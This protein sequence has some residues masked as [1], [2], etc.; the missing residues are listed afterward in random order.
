MMMQRIASTVTAIA[1]G[2]GLSAAARAAYPE[3]PIKLVV[4]YTPAGSGDQLARALAQNVGQLLQQPVVVE[5]KPGAST[6]IGATQV[7]R[8]PADGYTLFLASNASMVLNPLLY[9]SFPYDPERDFR[10]VAIVADLPLVVITNDKSG[11]DSMQKFVDYA[12]QNPGKLNYASVG[13]GNPL[14]LATELLLGKY[15]IKATHVPYNGSAPALTSLMANDTQLMIDVISTSLPLIKDG[16][17]RP[18]A[19]TSTKRLKVLPDIPTVSEIG[20]SDYQ[21]ATWF[22]I[23]VPAK[24]PDTV[25]DK[26]R[27]AIDRTLDEARFQRQFDTLGLDIQEPRTQEQIDQ[28]VTEDRKRW[29]AVIEQN[30]ISLD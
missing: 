6:K 13:K 20:K 28:Y 14:H 30:R 9:K 25:V 27:A 15:G 29:K 1:L 12:K 11:L 21:A 8:S 5:N 23:A 3:K 18:L 7:A 24:T 17:I 26:L 16:K 22:G 4:P 19:V 10:I 2:L